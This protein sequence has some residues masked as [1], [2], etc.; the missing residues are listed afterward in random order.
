MTEPW[1]AAAGPLRVAF[2]PGVMPDKWAAT[3]R[4]RVPEVELVL[5]PS[6]DEDQL[7]VLRDGR[8][9]VCFLRLPVDREGLNVIPLY[10][11]VAVVVVPKDHVVAAFDEVSVA[12]LAD[13]H[14]LQDPDNVPE[15]RDLAVEVRDRTRFPVPAMTTGET[16]ASIAA[17]AGIAIVPMSI[18]RLHHRK[19][20]T[21]RPVT[22]VAG[23]Q[24][25]L[26]WLREAPNAPDDRID[27]FIGIV[28]GRTERSSRTV[29]APPKEAAG[30]AV[31]TDGPASKASGNARHRPRPGGSR[32]RSSRRGRH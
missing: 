19:E 7:A 8:A 15:W 29:S 14:L 22:G 25:G 23:S 12:D 17:G 10:R 21:Y 3:W 13:E 6:A 20:L 28:R 9:D 32:S 18:A 24:I 27:Y 30:R 4:R 1:D 26:A 5:L 31:S 16:F 2:V 11:E